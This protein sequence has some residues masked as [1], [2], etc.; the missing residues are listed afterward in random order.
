MAPAVGAFLLSSIKPVIMKC[1]TGL[2][3]IVHLVTGLFASAL[4]TP[5]VLHATQPLD[6]S[7]QRTWVFAVGVLEWKR[8][9]LW[10][11]F[12]EAKRNRRDE[13]LVELF[14]KQGVDAERIV[15]LQ[16][17]HCTKQRIDGEFVK[18]LNQTKPGDLLVFYFCGHGYRHRQTG[19]TWFA[20]YDAGDQDSSAWNVRGIFDTLETHFRGQRVLLLADCCHSG[21]LFDEV[22]RRRR[23]AIAYAAL[24]SSYSH[25][26]S[27]G[28][29]T[30]TDSL[31]TGLRGQ[32][33]V[34]T[35]RDGVVELHEL[36]LF[37]ELEMAFIE[38]QK[39]MFAAVDN[40]PREA[41][42][43]PTR[44]PVPPH[45]G[46]RVEVLYE[47]RWYKARVLDVDDKQSKVHYLDYDDSWDEWVTPRR[48][49]A[50]QPVEHPVN[51]RVEV[52]WSNDQ[53]WYPATVLKSWYGLHL[54]HYDHCDSSWDEWV[55]PSSI[56]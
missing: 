47:G 19:E 22:T 53:K 29:W 45:V 36:A 28:N 1:R 51:A 21:A 42:L 8:G 15:Y 20:N 11:P 12:P 10:S 33:T 46:D 2:L 52:Y 55:G 18:L 35:D 25:N 13:Q 5:A 54:I 37:T 44:G 32:S 3:K 34:D 39:S 30:F 56:R 48:L 41:K 24:T 4:S 49:R 14:R 43:A 9:D 40:F 17:S 31:L 38:G 50:Y 27:T 26:T 16:D 23:S 7:P 6:W